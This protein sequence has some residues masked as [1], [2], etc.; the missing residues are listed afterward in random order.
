MLADSRNSAQPTG[1]IAS[2]TF[3]R[4]RH[5][6][7]WRCTLPYLGLHHVAIIRYSGPGS[8]KRVA[9]LNQPPR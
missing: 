5:S 3:F 2:I 7:V 8:R 6:F 1:V 9:M 4:C